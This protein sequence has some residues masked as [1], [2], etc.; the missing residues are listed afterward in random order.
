[1]K[2]RFYRLRRRL[3]HPFDPDRVKAWDRRFVRNGD[4]IRPKGN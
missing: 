4:Y 3:R 2:I 1:V